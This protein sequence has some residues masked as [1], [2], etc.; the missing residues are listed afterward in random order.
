MSCAWMALH[1]ALRRRGTSR[2]EIRPEL[3]DELGSGIQKR[4]LARGPENLIEDEPAHAT[5]GE[6][7][8]QTTVQSSAQSPGIIQRGKEQQQRIRDGR[9][10]SKHRQA[11]NKLST[12]ASG[13][14]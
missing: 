11:T 2:V 1:C 9:R 7:S 4:R 3:E 12:E 8:H 10:Y 14:F 5:H 13:G 6:C